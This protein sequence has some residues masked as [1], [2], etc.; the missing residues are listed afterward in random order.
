MDKC[1][2]WQKTKHIAKKRNAPGGM[3]RRIGRK[4]RGLLDIVLSMNCGLGVLTS[5]P[6]RPQALMQ[7]MPDR[8]A[9]R[10]E[11]GAVDDNGGGGKLVN[12]GIE[13]IARDPL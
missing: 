5:E 8:A 2:K 7:G 10:A 9:G 13:V 12:A 11:L 1:E 4:K 3:N 6:T